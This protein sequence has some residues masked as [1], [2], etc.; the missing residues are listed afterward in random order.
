VTAA[1]TTLYFRKSGEARAKVT[2]LEWGEPGDQELISVALRLT[3]ANQAS[4]IVVRGWNPKNKREIVGRAK[5]GDKTTRMDGS[6]TAGDLATV[7]FGQAHTVVVSDE[8]RT[9]PLRARVCA[10]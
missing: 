7:A 6:Q 5:V 8:V 1:N 4:E 3:T 10:R 2:T 9:F